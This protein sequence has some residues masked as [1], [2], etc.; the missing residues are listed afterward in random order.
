MCLKV[1]N[2]SILIIWPNRG[3]YSLSVDLENNCGI[4]PKR[5]MTVHVFDSVIPNNIIN[6]TTCDSYTSPSGKRNW[7]TS[8][9]YTD[10]VSDVN[11]LDSVITI[12]LSIKRSYSTISLISCDSNNY[13]SPSGKYTWAS[14]GTYM[15]TISNVAGCDSIITI[16]LTVNNSS[17]SNISDTTCDSYISPSG[18]YIW[19]SSGTYIDTIS[20]VTGCDSI[21]T[22]NL[23]VNNSSISN[24][25]DTICNSYLSPSGKYIWTSRGTYMDTITNEIGCDSIVIIDLVFKCLNYLSNTQLLPV[26]IY[27]NPTTGNININLGVVYN[28]VTIELLDLNSQ[29]IST[30]KYKNIK[31]FDYQLN[32]TSGIY[33]LKVES[34]EKKTVIKKIIVM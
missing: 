5:E 33:F 31:Q 13:I 4:S 11:D 21:I 28:E 6:I 26:T 2:D 23:T 25:S 32:V 22:I 12:I 18:K 19:T 14:S 8:G 34:N 16:N 20:N 15:D 17:I 10:T 1:S 29:K 24:I 3:S 27:P 9:I 7:S 30:K